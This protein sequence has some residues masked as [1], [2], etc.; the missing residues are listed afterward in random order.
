MNRDDCASNADLHITCYI[1]ST[2]VISMYSQN[3]TTPIRIFVE[4]ARQP[5]QQPVRSSSDQALSLCNQTLLASTRTLPISRLD[6]RLEVVQPTRHVVHFA[7]A[8][9][10]TFTHAHIQAG[11]IQLTFG[12]QIA[13]DGREFGVELVQQVVHYSGELG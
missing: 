9:A 1:S 13:A 8:S 10:R 4:A 2:E 3:K 12:Q 7:L 11:Q 5:S 6:L